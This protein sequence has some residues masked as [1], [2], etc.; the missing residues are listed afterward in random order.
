MTFGLSKSEFRLLNQLVI[1]P[2]NK[3]GARV[4]VF[5]SRARGKHHPFSDIDLLIEPP[6]SGISPRLLADVREGIEESRFPIKVDLVLKDHL[7]ESYKTQV[8]NERV[9][10]TS[11]HP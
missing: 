6:A 9:E 10:V 2:L 5:G 1:H 7:V 11:E 4:F 8:L 3:A